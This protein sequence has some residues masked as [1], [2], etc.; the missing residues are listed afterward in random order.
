MIR[1]E[2]FFEDEKS[3]PLMARNLHNY[4][5][6]KNAEEVIARV[7]GWADYL[8][9]SSACEAGKFCDEPELVRIFERDAERTYVTPDRTSSTDPAVQ[10][11]H[12]ACKKRI[13]ERQRRHIDTLRMAAV[14]TQD[15]HQGMG[16]IAAFLGL[17]LSPE[18]AAGVVLALHRSEKHSA[19]YF[20]GAPQAFLA[21][22]RV[23]GELM[24]KRMPQ[25]HAHLSSK[26]VLPEMYCS[27]WFIGLGLHVLPF[28]ALLDFYELYFEHGVEGYLFKFA[29]MYMQTFEN[30]LMECKDTHSVMT[31][32]RAEDPA[33]DWKL[34]KQLAELEE[35]HKVF[36]EIVND[37]LSIDLAEFDLPKMRAERRAQ[38]AG[39]VERA[40]QRE[41]ELKDMYGDDEIVFSDEEDD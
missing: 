40:K 4:L 16:Y 23:F 10:E 3:S 31:I 35:K 24:Q 29:L 39:E 9:E 15:Y 28:E 38:V 36:E 22:C 34:P 2:N 41:Q 12:N 21:D 14:E 7:K 25:L 19:G 8:P 32:L 27:K 17:F 5:S 33:C 20:K 26:G 37:A 18:E 1:T 11:K 30:I 13:E 6:E